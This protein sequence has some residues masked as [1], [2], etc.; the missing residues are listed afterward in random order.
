MVDLT[1]PPEVEDL[2][3]EGI[4]YTAPDYQWEGK[5]LELWTEVGGRHKKGT[6]SL[7]EFYEYLD[8]WWSDHTYE[9]CEAN[10]QVLQKD[11]D[12]F[13]EVA[14]RDKPE[15]Y[16]PRVADRNNFARQAPGLIYKWQTAFSI[17]PAPGHWHSPLF[18]DL[19]FLRVKAKQLYRAKQK[20]YER[21]VARMRPWQPMTDSPGMMPDSDGS[22]V[23]SAGSEPPAMPSIEH[24]MVSRLANDLNAFHTDHPRAIAQFI[25]DGSP[26]Y[27]S[28]P[29]ENQDDDSD[30]E[31]D[32]VHHTADIVR[33]AADLIKD[34]AVVIEET[35]K[36][37]AAELIHE[38]SKYVLKE[39]GMV[40]G[41][42][43]LEQ[44]DSFWGPRPGQYE[45]AAELCRARA[46]DIGKEAD[47]LHDL[48]Q[49]SDSESW[50]S[51]M[52]VGQSM[53]SIEESMKTTLD[54]TRKIGNPRR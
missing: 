34:A 1:K 29:S 9:K 39:S 18:A 4:P 52:Y 15:N 12:R 48:A 53:K 10:V 8:P 38:T 50:P 24:P 17:P 47:R 7:K 13:C 6:L 19:L 35:S 16:N 33:D 46:R 23:C 26:R 14:Y 3:P 40:K 27:D 31:A 54:Y 5:P 32:M 45:E 51:L 28:D 42:E 37:M 30:D 21:M 25:A 43:K 49:R 11:L 20:G 41:K 2:Y 36:Y 22:A 44:L